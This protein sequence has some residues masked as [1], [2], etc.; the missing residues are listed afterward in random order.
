M[1][2]CFL[3]YGGRTVF[4]KMVLLRK[5]LMI[6]MFSICEPWNMGVEKE[7]ESIQETLANDN[8]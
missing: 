6:Q 1:D 5:A 8:V 4:L 3:M 2:Y 7:R